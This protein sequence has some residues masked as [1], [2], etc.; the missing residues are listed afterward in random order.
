ML[1]KDNI[2]GNNSS[3]TSGTAAVGQ[4]DQCSNCAD[5]NCVDGDCSEG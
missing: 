1:Y 5:C 2:L 3:D 4:C